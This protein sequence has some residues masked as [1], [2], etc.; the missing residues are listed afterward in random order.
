[1]YVSGGLRDS[2]RWEEHV[3]SD[4]LEINLLTGVVSR[5][6]LRLE[7]G[8]NLYAYGHTTVHFGANIVIVCA[9]QCHQDPLAAPGSV[10]V[11][12]PDTG[13]L[14]RVDEK[15][16]RNDLMSFQQFFGSAMLDDHTL[17]VYGGTQQHLPF[18]YGQ[19]ATL[20]LE[21]ILVT[22]VSESLSASFANLV[23]SSQFSDM[24]FITEDGQTI[25]AHKVI[26]LS[27][28]SHL[29]RMFSSGMI[30]SRKS[31]VRI[32]KSSKA[33]LVFLQYLYTNSLGDADLKVSLLTEVLTLAD[34]YMQQHLKA[35]CVSMLLAKLPKLSVSSVIRLFKASLLA[36]SV[37]LKAASSRNFTMNP[38]VV[39]RSAAYRSLA[40]EDEEVYAQIADLVCE[41]IVP[42]LKRP[43]TEAAEDCD[44]E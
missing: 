43:K 44:D 42:A 6:H 20:N 21:D 28:C 32:E 37:E 30:E 18:V 13:A 24:S 14:T 35:L 19:M 29:D 40:Q 12:S 23:G 7:D 41:S 4:M 27:R 9:S 36:N 22:P 10:F 39:L 33:V 15:F 8:R 34:M 3:F 11:Y 17:L 16:E 2:Y 1:M 25:P 38:T 26:V 31:Q 5:K